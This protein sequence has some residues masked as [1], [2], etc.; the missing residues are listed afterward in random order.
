MHIVIDCL[1]IS[2]YIANSL[3][4]WRRE[5]DGQTDTQTKV[6]WLVDFAAELMTM[7]VGEWDGVARGK[8]EAT[9]QLW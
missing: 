5:I 7:F 9:V 3:L 1:A 2:L 4:R 8:W 6:Q